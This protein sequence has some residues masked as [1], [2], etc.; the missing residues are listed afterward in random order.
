MAAAGK[1]KSHIGRTGPLSELP[2]VFDEL[3]AGQQLPLRSGVGACAVLVVRLSHDPA[4]ATVA[5]Q[6]RAPRQR[7]LAGRPVSE[8]ERSVGKT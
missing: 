8:A 2:A 6:V 1:V 5:V 7:A 4:V 3:E